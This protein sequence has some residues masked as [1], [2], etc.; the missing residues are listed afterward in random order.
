M[1]K[2]DRIMM[3]QHCT[4]V[5]IVGMQF[6]NVPAHNNAWP[7]AGPMLIANLDIF[8][9]FFNNFSTNNISHISLIIWNFETHTHIYVYI[10]ILCHFHR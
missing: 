2:T 3:A 6:V 5:Y 4:M 7:S 10:E 9:F 1:E 8:F